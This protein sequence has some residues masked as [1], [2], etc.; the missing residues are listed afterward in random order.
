MA[1]RDGIFAGE[2]PFEIARSWLT[3]AEQSEPNDPNAVAL[4]TVDGEGLPSQRS[5]LHGQL[6][7]QKL[8]RS[9]RRRGPIRHDPPFG[10]DTGW[11]LWKL[12]FGQMARFVCM[13]GSGGAAKQHKIFGPSTGLIL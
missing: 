4:A 11:P 3:D 7:W 6:W 5:C 13:T 8:R 1:E 10:A 9:R 2:D 12:S